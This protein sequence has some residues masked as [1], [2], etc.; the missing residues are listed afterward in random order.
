MEEEIVAPATPVEMRPTS[1]E[2]VRISASQLFGTPSPIVAQSSAPAAAEEPAAAA[3]MESSIAPQE[4]ARVSEDFAAAAPVEERQAAA[5]EIPAQTPAPD[6]APFV[7][8]EPAS[9]QSVIEQP[10]IEQPVAEQPVAEQPIAEQPI[11]EKAPETEQTPVE[12]AP[13]HPEAVFQP[14][15]APAPTHVEPAAVQ[16]A[17][18]F[19]TSVAAAPSPIPKTISAPVQP[20]PAQRVQASGTSA[21]M[22]GMAAPAQLMKSIRALDGVDGAFMATADGLL[23]AS[24]MPN[25]NE[26][27]LA[28]FAP[29]VF[30]QMSKYS[31]MARLG[32][33]EAIDLHL[34]TATIHVRK[35]GKVYL[36]VLLP[37]GQSLPA[38]AIGMISAFLKPHAT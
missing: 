26:N 16:P 20:A 15:V 6:A 4:M 11:A 17:P 13:A 38:A 5:P 34:G 12:P 28:A 35:T 23:I 37:G 25:A 29:T 19:T 9:E 36:G 8:E 14:P 18:P 7:A 30:S 21:K 27:L 33:P 10:I 31:G 1:V 3:E 2:A 24:D 22:E 32:P